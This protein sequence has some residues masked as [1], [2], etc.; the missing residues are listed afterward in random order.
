MKVT[1]NERVLGEDLV[2][3]V[4]F[5]SRVINAVPGSHYQWDKL[6]E[7]SEAALRLRRRLSHDAGHDGIVAYRAPAP[8]LRPDA[9]DAFVAKYAQHYDVG[10]RLWRGGRPDPR[11]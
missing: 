11:A 7:L 2:G 9:V 1:D 3:L 4:D 10:R 5:F 6:A 8:R